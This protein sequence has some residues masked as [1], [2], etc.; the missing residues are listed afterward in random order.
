M[1][2]A[3]TSFNLEALRALGDLDLKLSR[4]RRSL[5]RA[6]DLASP[7]R[8]RVVGIKEE[9]VQLGLSQRESQ[10]A[11]KGLELLMATA[12]A[13]RMK[14]ETA[15]NQAKSNAEFQNLTALMERKQAE[16]S[17]FETKVLEGYDVHEEGDA[18]TAAG[19]ERLVSQEKELAEAMVRVKAAEEKAQ[20]EIDGLEAKRVEAAAKISDKHLALYTQ[21]LEEHKDTPLSE[22]RDE[23]CVACGMKARP[24]QISLARGG[25]LLVTCGPCRRIL[26]MRTS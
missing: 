4:A 10:K 11:I 3:E 6:G 2:T 23:R 12:E 21:L 7:Q 18:K 26:W 13:E 16:I 14:A 8:N 17:D 20:G 9:L 19:K 24:E 1:A 15:L 5:E 22:I 25:K